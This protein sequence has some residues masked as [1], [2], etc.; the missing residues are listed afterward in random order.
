M[1]RVFAAEGRAVVIDV[2]EPELRKGEVLIKTAFSAVSTG[3]ETHILQNMQ[4]LGRLARDEYPGFDEKWPQY[5]SPSV[6]RDDPLPREPHPD[7]PALGYSAAGTVLAVADN[8]LDLKPGDR[9]ACSG[10]QCS[11][12]TEQIAAPRN[13]VVPVPEGVSLDQAAFVTL[14]SIATEAVRKAGCQFGETI[15]IT[16]LGLLGLLATQ[17]ARSAGYYVV[18]LDLDDGRL[19]TAKSVGAGWTANVARDDVEA[20]VREATGG[21]GADAVLLTVATESS[22]PLNQA[23]DIV[24]QRGTVVAVGQFGMEVDRQRWFHHEANLTVV[25]AY[26]PG[27]Y[28]PVYEEGNVDFPIGFGRWAENRN[29][30]HFLRLVSEGRVDL[31]PIAP[32]TFP[33]ERAPE[34][35]ELLMSS[36]RP[37]T[38]VFTYGQA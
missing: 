28:D 20:I 29:M 23:F 33:V 25:L 18:A 27:R 4:R 1:K 2:P 16:G 3:T 14:G 34:A 13:L 17:I 11:W 15:V 21:F 6:R 10:S 30:A 32:I 36:S 12:H 35:Y 5:R 24:R 9:V 22:E 37:P 7:Y 31:G 8:V 19:A 38:V 26:G